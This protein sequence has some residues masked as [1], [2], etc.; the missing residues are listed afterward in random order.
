MLFWSLLLLF[1]SLASQTCCSSFNITFTLHGSECESNGSSL[2]DF[3]ILKYHD[4][5]GNYCYISKSS[6]NCSGNKS[7]TL[8]HSGSSFHI[9]L[10]WYRTNRKCLVSGVSLSCMHNHH[11]DMIYLCTTSSTCCVSQKLMIESDF[12]TEEAPTMNSLTSSPVCSNE[13]NFMYTECPNEFLSSTIMAT[14]TEHSELVSDMYLSSFSSTYLILPTPLEPSQPISAS[15]S[16]TSLYCPSDPPW[17]LTPAG[18]NATSTC[19]KGLFNAT[20]WCNESGNWNP[21]ICFSYENFE[22]IILLASLSP[23]DALDSLLNSITTISAVQTVVLLDI[24]VSSNS[25]NATTTEEF[26]QL[27]LKT[28]DEFLNETDPSHYDEEVSI[29]IF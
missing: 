3:F 14:T 24:I 18:Y 21:V 6:F 15:P 22:A 13:N 23:Y 11:T 12:C 5:P 16:P 26:G 10:Y 17:P 8:N 25:R 4:G 19:H 20:R 2:A 27:L 7:V 29:K 1:L 28:F 9:F